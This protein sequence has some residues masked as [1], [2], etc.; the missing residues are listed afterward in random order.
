MCIRDSTRA[1]RTPGAAV[2]GDQD[3]A[4][5]TDCPAVARVGEGDGAESVRGARGLGGPDR[6]TVGGGEDGAAGAH[7]PAVAG[8]GKGH[9]EQAVSYT[10]LRAHETVLDLVC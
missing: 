6:A 4:R 3:R 10:H 9:G 2:T 8:V 1:S 5:I 7:R